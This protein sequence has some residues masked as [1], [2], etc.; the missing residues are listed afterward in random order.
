MREIWIS[1]WL[2]DGTQEF[3][4]ITARD[5][6]QAEQILKDRYKSRYG[7]IADYGYYDEM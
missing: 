2:A 1:Y 6:D 7:G 5:I 4:T 3:E